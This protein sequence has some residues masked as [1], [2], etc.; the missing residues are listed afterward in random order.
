MP[1]G[2]YF[3]F[4]GDFEAKYFPPGSTGRNSSVSKVRV[5]ACATLSRRLPAELPKN[6]RP[7][8]KLTGL[9]P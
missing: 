7:P 3:L 4:P 6:K 8:R 2:W 1:A 9:R 5:C